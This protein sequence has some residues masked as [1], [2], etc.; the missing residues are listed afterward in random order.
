LR[1]HRITGT[2]S[3][4]NL[5]LKAIREAT[6]SF[7]SPPVLEEKIGDRIYKLRSEYDV[8][9]VYFIHALLDTGGLLE[10]GP[11]RKLRLTAKGE[12]FLAVDPAL[13]VWFLLETWWYHT[14]WLIAVRAGGIGEYLPPSFELITLD[15][16]NGL[17]AERAISYERFAD[18]LI[19]Q[20][21]LKWTAPDMSG[22]RRSLHWSIELMVIKILENFSIVSRVDEDEWIGSYKFRK[23]HAFS[24]T[25]P[26]SGL[27]KAVAG[28]VLP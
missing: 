11:G 19:A 15:H 24:I 22:A 8:W 9:S 7:V 10:G 12:Q 4:G 27:L 5:P 13:Q 26:G 3:S 21:G 18:N 1:D 17:P 23:L 6:A 2:Q 25:K 16:L 14:N 20:T 28:K